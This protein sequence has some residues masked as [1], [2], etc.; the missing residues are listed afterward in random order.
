MRR[1]DSNESATKKR[2]KWMRRKDPNKTATTKNG[3]SR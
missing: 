2:R 3:R 1:K